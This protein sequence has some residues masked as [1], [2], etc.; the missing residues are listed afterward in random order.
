MTKTVSSAEI[1]KRVQSLSD[2]CRDAGLRMTQQRLEIFR[3][4]ART[5]EHPDAE[6]V[7]TRVRRRLPNISLDTVYRNL[8]Q[9][10][11]LGLLSRVD[12]LCGRARFDANSDHHHHFVCVVCERVIDIYLSEEET[13][14][15]PRQ[16]NRF[17]EAASLHLQVR[18]VC[19]DCQKKKKK[20]KP[21]GDSP[22]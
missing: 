12:L 4:V 20:S 8:A 17:G 14:S 3:A 2:A 15:L 18:G 1:K 6:T 16:S 11:H 13:L 10:E 22:L 5:G 21:R 7:H 9:L 19:N